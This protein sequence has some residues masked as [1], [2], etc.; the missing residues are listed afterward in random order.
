MSACTQGPRMRPG[1]PPLGLRQTLSIIG[2]A[3]LV[4]LTP[5]ARADEGGF[6][7]K[8][9]A[10]G[11]A[12]RGGTAQGIGEALCQAINGERDK[13]RIR[14]IP[15]TTTGFEYNVKGVVYGGLTMGLTSSS[16]LEAEY[17]QKGDGALGHRLR[18]VMSL[19]PM[20][21]GVIARSSAGIR[22]ITQIKGHAIN[23]G[24]PGSGVRTIADTL[25]RQLKLQREDFS[26]VTELN[27]KQ[28]EEAFCQGKTDLIIQNLGHPSPYY[29]NLIENCGGEF[30]PFPAPLV[31]EIVAGDPQMS[32]MD[33]PGGMYRGHDTP[34]P[35]VGY[36]AVLATSVDVSNEAVRRFASTI[37]ARLPA[38]KQADPVL[39]ELSADTMFRGIG[40]VPLHPGVLEYL[41]RQKPE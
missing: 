10:I 12:N 11:T 24:N 8:F 36:V 39:R 4:G 2:L 31:Q 14:C 5:P 6:R 20:P 33:I 19:Y 30:V 29:R 35:S 23:I 13:S 41:N 15:Y 1:R 17:Q 27:S 18:V 3:A 37:V 21:V 26:R 25:M 16:I 40:S 34:R 28:M 7:D 38:L 9:I 22:D 32:A